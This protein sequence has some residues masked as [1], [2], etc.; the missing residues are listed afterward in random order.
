M[1]GNLMI[2]SQVFV[3]DYASTS[4]TGRSSGFELL[5]GAWGTSA[6]VCVW[7]RVAVRSE[8]RPTFAANLDVGRRRESF[9]GRYRW[10]GS[11]SRDRLGIRQLVGGETSLDSWRLSQTVVSTRYDGRGRPALFKV[12]MRFS[13]ISGNKRRFGCLFSGP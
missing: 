1:G 8:N 13:D 6:G 4:W 9:F 3:S 7:D 11:P 10:S 5:G 2:L 12:F